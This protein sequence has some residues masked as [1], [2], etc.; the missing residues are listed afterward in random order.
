MD[1][2]GCISI[3]VCVCISVCVTVKEEGVQN[4]RHR[5]LRWGGAWKVWQGEQIMERN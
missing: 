3:L 2:S 5:K 1:S 4:L